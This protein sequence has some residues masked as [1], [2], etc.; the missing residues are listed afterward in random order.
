M[1]RSIGQENAFVAIPQRPGARVHSQ[2]RHA[3]ELCAPEIMPKLV[4]ACVR[5]AC[6]E[7]D[8]D[9]FPC[10]ELTDP[11]REL[12]RIKIRKAIAE[13][14]A[15]RMEQVLTVKV[16]NRSLD[17]GFAGHGPKNNPV[18]ALRQVGRG[19]SDKRI[20][21]RNPRKS[22]GKL[23]E[24]FC[25]NRIEPH[26]AVA[27]VVSGCAYNLKG[28]GAQLSSA[29]VGMEV[30]SGFS[31]VQALARSRQSPEDTRFSWARG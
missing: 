20:V 6:V 8:A 9:Q 12:E 5:N 23:Y 24:C 28:N 3:Q 22:K 25:V 21:G 14:F 31:F 7:M 1:S 30:R 4:V 26:C 2:S 11:R 10:L 29:P 18:R 19:A 27:C 13:R 16:S 17:R 15:C